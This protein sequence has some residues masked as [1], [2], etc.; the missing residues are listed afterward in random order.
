M[1]S[2]GKHEAATFID[3]KSNGSS[4]RGEKYTF[5]IITGDGGTRLFKSADDGVI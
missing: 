1:V 3:T 5:R 4:S 2:G